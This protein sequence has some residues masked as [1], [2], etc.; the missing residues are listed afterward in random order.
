MADSTNT[1]VIAY[2]ADT[3]QAQRQIR[4][5]QVL[6]R[7]VARNMGRDMAKITGTIGKSFTSLSKKKIIDPKTSQQAVQSMT[8]FSQGVKMADGSTKNLVQ[9]TTRMNGKIT[10]SSTAFKK[11]S[12]NTVG[13]GQNIARL[14]KRAALTIPLW[15]VLRGVMQGVTRTIRDGLK[16]IASQD[17]AYQ[18]ARRNIEASVRSQGELNQSFAKLK[19][20]TLALSLASGKSIED[21]TNAF[22]KFVTVGFDAETA[23]VGMQYATKL[24]VVEFGDATETANAFARAMRVMRDTSE[25]AKSES[26]QLAEAMALTDQLWQSNAFEI[27]EF[28]NNLLK[29]AGTAKV[30]N[31]STKETLTLLATLS[32]GGLGASG[33]R[34]LTTA[35]LKSLSNLDEVAKS[36]NINL[37]PA[38]DSTYEIITK[39][40][41]ALGQLSSVENAPKEL[42]TTLRELFQIRG[43]RIFATLKAMSGTLKENADMVPDINK[44]NTAFENVTN[45]TGILADRF[46]NVNREI[47]KA[48]VTGIVGGEDFNDSLKDIV[49]TL[50]TMQK[51][52][53][54][55]GVAV[56]SIFLKGGFAGLTI[57]FE[58]LFANLK[59][60]KKDVKD[61]LDSIQSDIETGLSGGLNIKDLK[62]TIKTLETFGAD[63]LKMDSSDF[64]KFTKELNEQLN[65]QLVTQK[66]LT[67][68]EKKREISLTQEI[69]TNDILLKYSLDR[70]KNAGILNSEILKTE[71]LLMK[72]LG[73][74]DTYENSL[75]R[76]L[77]KQKA[78]NDE[79]RLTTDVSTTATKLFDIAKEDGTNIA[80]KI[81]QVLSGEVDF[82]SFIRRGGEAVEIFKKNFA[83]IF[84]AQQAKAFFRGDT[85]AGEKG[86]RGGG[87]ITLPEE[88]QNLQK[89]RR[90]ILLNAKMELSYA[91]RRLAI[92]QKIVGIKQ[93]PASAVQGS[94]SLAE[95]LALGNA[96]ANPA[97]AIS[98]DAMALYNKI[99][100]EAGPEGGAVNVNPSFEI[101][102]NAENSEDLNNKI[103]AKFEKMKNITKKEIKD[104][105]VGKQSP[106]L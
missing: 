47:G 88:D 10:S 52:S 60:A 54:V 16:A 62:A 87:R 15:L 45:T 53:R 30:A 19:K 20:E 31:L 49:A 72:Q 102:I 2:I 77:D 80:K 75:N 26:Y 97:N 40:I 94:G 44:L 99:R 93:Q 103:D 1:K 27:K 39:M 58:I 18:K 95:A 76:Q 106:T 51:K 63:V 71:T 11:L 28:T 85:V 105:L 70:L 4:K 48:I 56:R 33:G 7:L 50:S 84:K 68:E 69:K 65:K 104:K 24:A 9:S 98:P 32:T 67:A 66:Q 22:Q 34:L 12:T 55:A 79:K 74:A 57:P 78:I 29:F 38:V 8:Q 92:E 90:Q 6:N 100:R 82:S 42:L 91:E 3:K 43:A 46:H 101:S 96:R 17:K 86:L 73:I 25:G 81:S 64:G 5:L 41:G 35:L 23:L 13:L 14:A 59:K 89:S 37:D 21:V 36:L 83:S 61:V